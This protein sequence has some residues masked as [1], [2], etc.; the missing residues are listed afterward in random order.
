VFVTGR[1]GLVVD[2]VHGV[3]V[4]RQFIASAAS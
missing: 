1:L 4:H 2:P 3:P